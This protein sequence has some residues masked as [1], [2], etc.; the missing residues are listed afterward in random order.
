VIGSGVKGR[1]GLGAL[2][3]ALLFGVA[4]PAVSGELDATGVAR[5]LQDW[6]DGT[7]DL[8]G[9]FEQTLASGAL[10]TGI[11]ESGRIYLK[12][13][14]KMRWDYLQ[15]ER[16]IALIDG[17]S[18]RVYLEE[19]RQLWEGSLEEDALL[20]AL[21]TGTEPLAGLFEA[22]LLATP[23]HGGEGAYRLQLVPRS[24]EQE[25]RHVVLTLRAPEFAIEVAEV[26]DGAGNLMQYRFA[27]MRR[28]SGLSEALFVFEPPPGTE[29]LRP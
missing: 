4:S 26:L 24:S 11:E 13:P 5:R 3:L 6:L 15:P 7:R 17:E 21:L 27:R 20:A 9:R 16:K 28:N 29:L 10:G 14:G 23:K 2:V 8:E 1:S 19:D 18:T 25:F 22:L 12:R